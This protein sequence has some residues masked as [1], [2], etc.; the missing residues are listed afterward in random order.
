MARDNLTNVD[1]A[2]DI[3]LEQTEAEID[4]VNRGGARAFESRDYDAA[5]ATLERA[6][7]LIA[8]RDR[9]AGLRREWAAL[10]AP[11][12]AAEETADEQ[13][14]RRDL[15]RLPRVALC[16]PPQE[17]REP[18][19]AL[20]PPAGAIRAAGVQGTVQGRRFGATA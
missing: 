15:G 8:F 19:D 9:T 7:L 1:A 18:L 2:F 5:R 20:A 3:L 6:G 16:H 14:Q 4:P 12:A 17:V 13:T 11:Q 10:A